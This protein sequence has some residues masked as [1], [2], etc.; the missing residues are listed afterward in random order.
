MGK[1]REG[2][3]L[4]MFVCQSVEVF[5]PLL[6]A[7]EE[8]C[9]GF[10]EGPFE[11]SIADLFTACAGLFAV[12]LLGALDEPGIGSE[13]LYRREAVDVFD[14]VEDNKAQDFTNSGDGF[15]Q[16]IGHR[17]MVVGHGDDVAFHLC[18]D[19]VIGFDDDKICFYHFPDR[20]VFKLFGDSLPVFRLGDASE[21]VGEVVLAPGVLDMGVE[22]GPFS[23][24]MI[25]SSQQVPCCSHIGR[26]RIGHWDHASS[27]QDSNLMGIELIVFG[28]A[29]VNGFHVEGM[30]QDKGDAVVFTDQRSSTM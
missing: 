14:L 28:F 18:Y 8:E 1:D 29:A 24:E 3:S 10:A 17:V 15:E 13:I 30:T 7:L 20:G 23:H 11:M 26:V 16:G 19:R 21:I 22:F 25:A 5:F 2:F 12:G 27:E 6:I 4:A 9:S